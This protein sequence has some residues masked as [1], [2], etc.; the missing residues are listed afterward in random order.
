M[1]K[2]DVL[3]LFRIDWRCQDADDVGDDQRHYEYDAA[4]VQ[5]VNIVH[6]CPNPFWTAVNLTFRIYRV[7]SNNNLHRY[8]FMCHTRSTS[9]RLK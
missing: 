2:V 4:I 1:N 8:L 7:M 3:Y 6:K 5:V 9:W